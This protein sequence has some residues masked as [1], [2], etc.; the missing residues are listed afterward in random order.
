MYISENKSLQMEI[1]QGSHDSLVSGHF[2]AETLIKILTLDF[3]WKKLEEWI[4]D[5]VR[6][7]D[8]CQ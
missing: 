6:S 3:Y 1:A 4:R 2:A 8:E 5:Y 7:C